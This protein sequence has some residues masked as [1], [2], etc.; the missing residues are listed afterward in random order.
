VTRRRFLELVDAFNVEAPRWLLA[1]AALVV[2]GLVL[3]GCAGPVVTSCH[4]RG[5]R[6]FTHERATRPFHVTVGQGFSNAW[7]ADGAPTVLTLHNPTDTT[8]AVHVVCEPSVNPGYMDVGHIEWWTCLAPHSEKL[9]L[10]EFMNV[11]ALHQVCR[12]EEAH[13]AMAGDCFDWQDSL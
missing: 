5:A 6:P 9:R 12:V 8:Q 1:A 10:T 11:D 4:D 3:A 7:F 13:R 2:L